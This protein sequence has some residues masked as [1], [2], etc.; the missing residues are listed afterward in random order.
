MPDFSGMSSTNTSKQ[1][2]HVTAD[3]QTKVSGKEAAK[4]RTTT[5]A[6]ANQHMKGLINEP[7]SLLPGCA[8]IRNQE[9]APHI[10]SR[11]IETIRKSTGHTSIKK[12]IKG[13]NQKKTELYQALET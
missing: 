2:H 13:S 12:Q 6:N 8:N 10:D 9:R 11:Q 5:K 4:H 1:P 3:H 7:K